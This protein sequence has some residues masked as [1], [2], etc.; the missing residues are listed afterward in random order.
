MA[1]PLD[2][3]LFREKKPFADS[4]VWACAVYSLVPF[5]GVVFVPLI[6][7]FGIRASLKG[8]RSAF[9]AMGLGLLVLIGQLV[10]WWLL[11]AVPRW[12]IRL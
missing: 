2:A 4:A 11:Y 10:L 7:V 6:F 9:K 5:V 3:A 8:E 12:G 1:D